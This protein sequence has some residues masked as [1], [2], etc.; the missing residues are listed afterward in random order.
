[1]LTDEYHVVQLCAWSLKL[2]TRYS[3]DKFSSI[4]GEYR[5]SQGPTNVVHDK[6][7]RLIFSIIRP[8]RI[9]KQIETL[10]NL[11]EPWRIPCR[12]RS[13]GLTLIEVW[14]PLALHPHPQFIYVV[15]QREEFRSSDTFFN[16]AMI[17]SLFLLSSI[18]ST[19]HSDLLTDQSKRFVGESIVLSFRLFIDRAAMLMKISSTFARW[20]DLLAQLLSLSK[21]QSRCWYWF[22]NDD[23][24]NQWRRRRRWAKENSKNSFSYS[25][26]SVSDSLWRFAHGCR[27]V[28][29]GFGSTDGISIHWTSE[30]YN[31]VSLS[32]T[33]KCHF[34]SERYRE[35]LHA[36]SQILRR[37]IHPINFMF[38]L[39]SRISIH[40]FL[41]FSTIKK[42]HSSSLTRKNHFLL[43]RH[44]R[45][46]NQSLWGQR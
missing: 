19:T 34:Y 38:L 31:S 14:D 12:L 9:P 7:S 35:D 45:E 15:G 8:G 39:D 23:C 37:K 40:S 36:L 10:E 21:D 2:S 28:K 1:M 5:Q 41:Y 44:I 20:S 22:L 17:R 46:R 29:R 16:V 25:R 18:N 27:R 30:D 11:W 42:E 33:E 4:V 3:E 32:E 6:W 24:K 26:W 13:Y 43:P